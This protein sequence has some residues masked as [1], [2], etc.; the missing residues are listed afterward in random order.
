MTG[1]GPGHAT[2]T[3][4]TYVYTTAFRS[5]DVG[6]AQAMAMILMV[7]IVALAFVEYRLLTPRVEAATA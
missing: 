1:G 2:E 5:I 4:A 3:A 6:Y 7:L